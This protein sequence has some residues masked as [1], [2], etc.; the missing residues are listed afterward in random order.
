VK[1]TREDGVGLSGTLYLPADYRPGTRLP[2][3][4]W[5]YPWDYIHPEIAGQVRISPHKFT[6]L[7][8]PSPPYS[9]IFA[10]QG[11]AVLDGAEMPIVADPMA[12]HDTYLEQMI[13]SARAAIEKLDEMG[14]ID[15]RKVGM[16]GHSYGG[17]STANL[18]ANSDLFAAGIARSGSHNRTMNPWGFRYERRSLWQAPEIYLKVSPFFQAD[19]IGEPVLFIHG[20]EDDSQ[21]S[22]PI[23]S[24]YM[25][26]ALRGMG[27]TARLVLLPLENHRYAARE[28]I[29][30]V[31]AELIDW[32]DLHLKGRM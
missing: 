31:A 10:L 32:F 23:H 26:Q 13:A 15:P 6:D 28:S 11:F 8:G 24:H 5:A 16:V 19:G 18:L 1:Y 9:K 17:F 2:L 30:H 12:V 7:R 22:K 14:I 25:Y 3:V 27:A 4:I 29:L 21:A 20:L